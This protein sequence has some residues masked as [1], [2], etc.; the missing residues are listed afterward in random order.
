M[1]EI[2]DTVNFTFD[3]RKFRLEEIIE[4]PDISM[5]WVWSGDLCPH[6]HKPIEK[7]KQ[8]DFIKIE[9]YILAAKTIENCSFKDIVV[10][11]RDTQK[12]TMQL[13]KEKIREILPKSNKFKHLLGGE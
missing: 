13:T 4:N 1:P 5:S 7:T 3:T 12:F 6:C 10:I 9:V 8:H 11:G 2:N